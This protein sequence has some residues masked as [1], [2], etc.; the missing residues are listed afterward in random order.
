[1]VADEAIN[2][3][4]KILQSVEPL[5]PLIAL[6]AAEPGVEMETEVS[7]PFPFGDVCR[8]IFRWFVL[9]MFAA[10]LIQFRNLDSTYGNS[11]IFM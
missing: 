1:M 4:A 11:T 8:S 2:T 3:A 5:D 9:I 7:G 10:T 6:P